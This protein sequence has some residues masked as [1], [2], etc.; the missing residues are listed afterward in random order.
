MELAMQERELSQREKMLRVAEKEISKREA[1]MTRREDCHHLQLLLEKYEAKS[2]EAGR[3]KRACL[4]SLSFWDP[5]LTSLVFLLA[6][7]G[8]LSLSWR[9]VGVWPKEDL[10]SMIRFGRPYSNSS[11]DS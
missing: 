3:L 4:V 10:P 2:T 8:L 9:L 5:C 7:I 1:R 6:A 11:L